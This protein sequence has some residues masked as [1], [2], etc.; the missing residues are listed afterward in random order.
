[1]IFESVARPM[2]VVHAVVG[3]TAV[4]STTHHA[5]YAVLSALGRQNQRALRRFGWIAP[6][7]LITQLLLGFALYPTYRIRVRA[8]D[9]DRNA[10]F[11]SQ[12][13]DFKEHLA[14]LSLMLVLA[15]ALAA[16]IKESPSQETRW[17]IAALSSVGALF[18]WT[19]A[20]IGLVVTA[21]HPV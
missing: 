10:P 12:L 18:V 2:L 15:A 20:V 9:F 14:A 19:T 11:F 7:S 1:M 13:F 4:F 8:L 5:A 3:F 21:R 17:S 16:R 6:S